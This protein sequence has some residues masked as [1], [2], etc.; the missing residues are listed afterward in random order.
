MKF[1][2]RHPV[3]GV[4][5]ARHCGDLYNLNIGVERNSVG[6]GLLKLCGII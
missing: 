6:G 3:G 1:V 2:G 5:F 4:V